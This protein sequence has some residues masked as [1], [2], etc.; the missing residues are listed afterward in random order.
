MECLI[1]TPSNH[2]IDTVYS[3]ISCYDNTLYEHS[4]FI[5]C[6]FSCNKIVVHLNCF[7]PGTKSYIRSYIES[8]IRSYIRSVQ[9]LKQDHG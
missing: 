6:P 5:E 2:A 9:D 3:M 1:D 4:P 8:Y 7:C